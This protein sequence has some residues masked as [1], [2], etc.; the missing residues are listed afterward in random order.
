MNT[1]INPF[2]DICALTIIKRYIIVIIEANFTRNR[3]GATSLSLMSLIAKKKYA[4]F[5]L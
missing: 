4:L 5:V 1:I 2:S 3:L